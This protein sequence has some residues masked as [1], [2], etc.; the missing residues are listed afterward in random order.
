M[1]FSDAQITHAIEQG[2][3]RTSTLDTSSVVRITCEDVVW[4]G[5]SANTVARCSA[6]IIAD[7]RE[8]L[9]ELVI[10]RWAPGGPT[11]IDMG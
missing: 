9:V 5:L 7:S 11:D 4:Y 10:K 3:R 1:P 6:R 2:L 8:Q